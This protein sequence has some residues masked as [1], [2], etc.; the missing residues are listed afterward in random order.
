MN[1][2]NE[3][4]PHQGPLCLRPQ[5][6]AVRPLIEAAHQAT[7]AHCFLQLPAHNF[8]GFPPPSQPLSGPCYTQNEKRYE[9]I[10]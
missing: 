3:A 7:G 10:Q 4:S 8:V 1:D 9:L 2:N 6:L 5:R